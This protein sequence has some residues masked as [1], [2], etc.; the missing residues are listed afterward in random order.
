MPRVTFTKNI[1]RHV[2]CEPC[3][4]DG[5]CVR[6]V[7]DAYFRMNETARGYVLDEQGEVRRHMIVFVDGRAIID[8]KKLTDAVKPTSEIYVMQAL[9]GG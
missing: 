8:R 3:D 2:G 4:V 7:L 1:Q 6:E 5:K 9:S